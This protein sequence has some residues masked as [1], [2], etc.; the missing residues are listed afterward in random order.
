MYK[1]LV[2]K[3]VSSG[4]CSSDWSRLFRKYWVS[5]WWFFPRCHGTIQVFSDYI[6]TF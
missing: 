1:P 6:G 2:T 3:L 4:F 5:K